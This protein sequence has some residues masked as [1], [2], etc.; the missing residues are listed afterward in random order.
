MKRSIIASSALFSL[1]VGLCHGNDFI[2]RAW[3]SEGYT[4]PQEPSTCTFLKGRYFAPAFEDDQ[5]PAISFEEVAEILRIQLAEQNYIMAANPLEAELLLVVHWGE[6][7]T[8]DDEPD[9]DAL[10]LADA[11]DNPT[12]D[13]LSDSKRA[14]NAKLLGIGQLRQ[15]AFRTPRDDLLEEAIKQDRYFINLLAYSLPEIRQRS[16]QTP[17]PKPLWATIFSMPRRQLEPEEAMSAISQRAAHYF[18]RD[19]K[20]LEMLRRDEQQAVVEIG[21]LEF[22]GTVEETEA[23]P[24]IKLDEQ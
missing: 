2:I 17:M 7:S 5:P 6:T 22:M 20:D 12:P 10:A 9:L 21:P 19:T 3:S 1:I 4:R 14:L 16:K 23:I 13:G 8:E 18:G 11:A 24:S 15:G